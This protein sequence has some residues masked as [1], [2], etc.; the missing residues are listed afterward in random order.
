[1]G[2]VGLGTRWL[3]AGG[4]RVRVGLAS[5]FAVDM[6]HRSLQ[7]AMRL[8]KAVLACL[9]DDLPLVYGLPNAQSVGVCHRLGY[10]TIGTLRRLV[11]VLRVGRYL[12]ARSGAWW[13]LSGL[14]PAIDLG[15]RAASAYTWRRSRGRTVQV[16][17]DFDE[18]FDALWQRA[19]ESAPVIGERSAEFLRWRY[20]AC[21]LRRYVTLGLLPTHGDRLQG[22]AVCFV[23]DG[24]VA[25]A[26]LL[27][28]GS[29]GAEGDLLAG[30][31]SWSRREGANSAAVE[32]MAAR[33]E[34][35]A[36]RLGFVERR[37]GRVQHVI[38]RTVDAA[39]LS[40]DKLRGWYITLGDEDFN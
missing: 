21:P 37:E 20:A 35:S 7:P 13:A 15:L 14:A 39:G 30:V 24:Q 33:L 10:R 12:R 28:D 5:D 29:D 36:R 4:K 9:G 19:A 1:V 27:T 2:T 16:L 25:V 22:Y 38:A 3:W 8:Q 18:R 32:C 26:D 31:L 34:G 11:K 23:H 40:E 6:D 17:P